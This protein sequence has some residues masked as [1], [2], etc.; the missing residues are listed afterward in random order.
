MPNSEKNE[1]I[2]LVEL[3]QAEQ[4]QVRNSLCSLLDPDYCKNGGICYATEQ[5]FGCHCPSE[6]TGERCEHRSPCYQYCLHGG[7][8]YFTNNG[9]PKC[10][11]QPHLEGD[12]CERNKTT[13]SMMS[14]D[15]CKPGACVTIPD[16]PSYC[17]CPPAFIGERCETSLISTTTKTP[18]GSCT[19]TTCKNGGVCRNI[20]NSYLCYC[21]KPYSGTNCQSYAG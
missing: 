12:R 17:Q 14:A 3:A 19:P 13:C 18:S 15:Y 7:L 9:Q 16:S 8:C 11:C 2:N 20:G 5:G 10:F 6:Y 1:T 4:I 21:Q